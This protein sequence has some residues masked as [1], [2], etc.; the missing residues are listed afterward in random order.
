MEQVFCCYCCG[1]FEIGSCYV[2]QGGLALVILL[3]QPTMMELQMG[4]TNPVEGDVFVW[5]VNH[6]SVVQTFSYLF[7][8]FIFKDSLKGFTSFL[9]NAVNT[10][11]HERV[12][13]GQ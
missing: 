2:A 9:P 1:F 12:E 10:L 13:K 11:T 4:A 7:S 6:Q 8:S 5:A 3:P